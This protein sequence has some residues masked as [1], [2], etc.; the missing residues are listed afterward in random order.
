MVAVRTAGLALASLVGVCNDSTVEGDDEMKCLV[1]EE[2]LE[3]LVGMANERFLANRER[4][5][6]FEQDL[7]DKTSSGESWE[8]GDSR[9]E[10]KRREGLARRE[11]LMEV[12]KDEGMNNVDEKDGQ[13][14]QTEGVFVS[15][16]GL[17][18]GI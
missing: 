17:E 11:A 7:F 8:D 18:V 12:A 1:S 2:Y 9:R 10:R 3:I 15:P 14:A 16:L 6:R 4:I 13:V 5:A